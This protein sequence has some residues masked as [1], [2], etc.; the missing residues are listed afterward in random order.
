MAARRLNEELIGLMGELYDI[1]MS[2]GE[3][4]RARAYKKAEETIMMVKTDITDVNQLKGM[5]GIGS[6][7]LSKLVEYV[8]TGTLRLLER[9]RDNPVN[10]FTKVY[11]IGPKKAKELVEKHGIKTIEKLRENQGLL[12][13][14]QVI[15]LK[16]YEDI[17][18]RIP[19][20]EIDEYKKVFEHI[21]HKKGVANSGSTMEIVGS[22][23]RGAED[24]GD[25]D[26]IIGDSVGD[27]NVFN[28]FL[29]A[30]VK[31]GIIIEV[32]S[33]GKIKSLVVAQLP[34]KRPRRVDFLFTSPDEYA[35]AVLYFTGSATFNTVMRQR[36]LDLGYSMNEHGIYKMVDG[37]K[38]TKLDFIFNNEKEIFDFLRLDYKKPS[39]R[40]DG[41]DVVSKEVITMKVKVPKKIVA[42]KKTPKTSVNKTLKVKRV[43]TQQ[44]A[45]KFTDEGIDYL[46]ALD[47]KT[48][49]KIMRDANDAYYNS[50]PFLTDNQFDI[51]KEHIEDTYPTNV[52][53][54]EI[55]A[56]IEKNKVKLPYH[57]GSM[58]KIKPDTKVLY[59]W[60][61]KYKGPYVLSTKLDGVS[62]LYY[63]EGGERKLF[64]R[65][66]GV[67]GQDISH[68]I[69]YLRL[70]E[71]DGITVRGELIMEKALYEDKYSKDFSN[72]RNLVSGIV[73]SKTKDED[74]YRDIR[75][76]AYEVV[77]PT[78]KPSAQFAFMKETGFETAGYSQVTELTNELLSEML[79]EW[80]TG[81]TY[82]IDGVIVAN[83]AVYDR[84]KG[85]PEHA[86]AFKMVLSDQVVEAK[87][88]DVLWT[89]SK[90][91]YLKPRIR[92]EPVVIGGA[93]IE[94][95]TAFNGAFVEENKI[96]VGAVVTMVRSGDVIPHIMNVITPASAAKMPDVKY[97]WND[98]H[99][100][101]ILV[102]AES[103]EIV[104]RKNIVGFFV[105]LG[106]EG[107][108]T[109]NVTKIM[110]AGFD[111]IEKILAMSVDDFLTVEGF[112][113]KMA[114]KIYN[115]I[116]SKVKEASLPQLMAATNLFG[117]GMGERKISAVLKELPDILTSE[118]SEATKVMSVSS[119]SGFA[120]KTAKLFVHNIPKFLQFVKDANLEYKLTE[121]TGKGETGSGEVDTQH[122]LF[123]K[124]VVMTGFRDKELEKKIKAVGGKIGSSVSKNT[125]VVLVKDLEEE[126]GKA[127][128]AKE[129]G[130]PLM[131]LETFVE[132][133][134]I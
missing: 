8:E 43:T 66:N 109:G 111:S 23:R 82:E 41:N 124:S 107:L 119:I 17:L 120:R 72:A 63:T 39:E 113:Q 3:P 54:K 53:V 57:M 49:V 96:G 81:F 47:E 58:D 112:K 118:H 131:L 76:V 103:D 121:D 18:E 133:Y 130:V 56:P 102:D 74:K 48:L 33:R 62:A 7:I 38:G 127:A 37:K 5:P 94:Y 128:K 71:V 10:I 44:H 20:S 21:F 84:K 40:K 83:D 129:V 34:G 61:L 30:L 31:K 22:Y 97:K 108:A 126:T 117:R 75:F 91:G 86:F 24:S 69:P 13:D 6:T 87:V 19:R 2:K 45:K 99:I 92:I 77:E 125:F 55:G 134:A 122:P 95:A 9:E 42:I 73:N 14:K 25:I 101:I 123:G 11:G 67:Y 46:K 16:Y 115:S 50:T 60:M 116:Q 15:G 88:I 26:I 59:K 51:L 12:N 78:L 106:V 114:D 29:D 93:R 89:P 28:R 4:F 35:F 110:N 27:V 90:D 98:T 36:A 132:K 52:A 79:I 68:M 85:N 65:G 70:P 32:L 104:R 64:T 100:D 1:M 105:R 80:R